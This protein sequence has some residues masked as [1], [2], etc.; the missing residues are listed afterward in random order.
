MRPHTLICCTQQKLHHRKK[1]HDTDE[2]LDSGVML[3]P[4]DLTAATNFRTDTINY[5]HSATDVKYSPPVSRRKNSNTDHE[6]ERPF[7]HSQQ[8]KKTTP[9]KTKKN[10]NVFLRIK[11]GH[12]AQMKNPSKKSTDRHKQDGNTRYSIRRG[13]ALARR[14]TCIRSIAAAAATGK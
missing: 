2:E 6:S 10:L 11:L 8:H 7:A 5:K 4:L 13:T 14:A 3:K 1:Q 12:R 9:P